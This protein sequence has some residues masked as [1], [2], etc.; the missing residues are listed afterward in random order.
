MARRRYGMTAQ[1]KYTS[2]GVEISLPAD[3]ASSVTSGL[4]FFQWSHYVLP[5]SA[6]TSAGSCRVSELPFQGRSDRPSG[7]IAGAGSAG[8]GPATP[9]LLSLFARF[10]NMHYSA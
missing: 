3:R 2:D 8:T 7:T 1:I 10:P 9:R 6:H 4:P 5:E